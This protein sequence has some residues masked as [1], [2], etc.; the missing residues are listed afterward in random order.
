MVTPDELDER[1]FIQRESKNLTPFKL[2]P[3]KRTNHLGGAG[4]DQ[5]HIQTFS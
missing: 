3:F 4:K 2:S 1:Y 5:P